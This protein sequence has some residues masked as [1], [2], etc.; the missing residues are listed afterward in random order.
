MTVVHYNEEVSGLWENDTESH[1]ADVL[2][3]YKNRFLYFL[4]FRS[5]LSNTEWIFLYMKIFSSFI[6]ES[7]P[8]S[9]SESNC[10][11]EVSR[12]YFLSSFKESSLHET[13][14][15]LKVRFTFLFS[16][17]HKPDLTCLSKNSKFKL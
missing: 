15:G 10:C 14:A 7:F 3:M 5:L 2:L 8:S 9:G 1:A 11:S 17:L 12:L 6:H 16:L 13:A 4:T